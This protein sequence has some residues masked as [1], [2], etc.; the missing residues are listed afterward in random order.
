MYPYALNELRVT[1]DKVLF[2]AIVFFKLLTVY[3]LQFTRKNEKVDFSIQS[4]KIILNTRFEDD[5]RQKTS[6]F[7]K[8]VLP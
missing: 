5:K 2:Y 7:L 8:S 3:C 6:I 4:L 1:T